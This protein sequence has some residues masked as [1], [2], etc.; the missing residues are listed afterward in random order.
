MKKPTDLY[1]EKV[2]EQLVCDRKHKA[3]FLQQLS[4]DVEAFA[5]TL[6]KNCSIHELEAEF[7]TPEHAAEAALHFEGIALVKDKVHT[8]KLIGI[9]V[10][11]AC[12][13]VALSIL[14][15]LA[16]CIHLKET[17]ANG[18]ETETAV[19]NEQSVPEYITNPPEN[20][21]SY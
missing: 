11:A 5:N 20:V 3:A 12:V 16:H 14:L 19:Y 2:K 8:N 6:G 15:Y 10:A 18:Y 7:G 9:T 4:A 13:I 21:R 1:I 17:C